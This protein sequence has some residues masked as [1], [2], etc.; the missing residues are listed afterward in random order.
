VAS[1]DPNSLLHKYS[2]DFTF[3][4]GTRLAGS[5]DDKIISVV[6]AGAAFDLHI[7]CSDDFADGYGVKN[8]PKAGQSPEQLPITNF[9]VWKYKNIDKASC[10][11]KS[12]CSGPGANRDEENEEDSKKK[13][14]SK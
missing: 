13:S 4:D 3:S 9:K 5:S 12:V 10:A 1:D 11:L 7:S 6:V 14:K 2:Y 8:G